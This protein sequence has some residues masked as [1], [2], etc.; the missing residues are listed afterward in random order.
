VILDMNLDGIP[1]YDPVTQDLYLYSGGPGSTGYPTAWNP[2]CVV[3]KYR[4]YLET[5]R[6]VFR[7]FTT[8]VVNYDYSQSGQPATQKPNWYNPADN[9]GSFGIN[10]TWVSPTIGIWCL[11]AWGFGYERVRSIGYLDNIDYPLY[12][13]NLQNNLVSLDK[14]QI[15]NGWTHITSLDDAPP[16]Q[17]RRKMPYDYGVFEYSGSELQ[18][19]KF[20]KLINFNEVTQESFDFIFLI[21]AQGKVLISNLNS[22]TLKENESQ[23]NEGGE[24]ASYK[25]RLLFV[26]PENKILVTFL[27]DSGAQVYGV[28][29]DV[30]YFIGHLTYGT[31]DGFIMIG[32]ELIGNNFPKQKWTPDWDYLGLNTDSWNSFPHTTKYAQ[33]RTIVQIQTKINEI[34]QTLINE[35]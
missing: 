34:N 16:N 17:S 24:F 1:D 33:Q 12:F 6:A 20:P 21:D 3:Y 35:V 28:K 18:N 22:A 29:N 32:G 30:V 19:K 27:G 8:P 7:Q 14:A 5:R 11:H 25:G 15:L 2:N 13:L 23:S 31:T 26:V 9:N 4:E 10:F